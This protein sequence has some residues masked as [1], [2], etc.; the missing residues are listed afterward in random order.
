MDG[1][2]GLSKVRMGEEEVVLSLSQEVSILN[3]RPSI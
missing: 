3:F 1:E 2:L